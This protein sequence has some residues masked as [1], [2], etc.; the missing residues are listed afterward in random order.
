[1]QARGGQNLLLKGY[2]VLDLSRILVGAHC[3]MMLADMGADVIK[4]EQRGTGDETRHWGPPFRGDPDNNSQVATYF[5]S[6]NRNKRSMTIDLKKPEGKQIVR[7]LIAERHVDIFIENF[8]PKTIRKL[9]LDYDSIKEMNSSLI[10]ASVGGYPQDS[11]WANKA[12]FDL[13]V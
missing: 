12:A 6:V 7:D 9:E 1:M 11:E 2:R 10:Y 3:S 13:T 5:M 8:M 4:V